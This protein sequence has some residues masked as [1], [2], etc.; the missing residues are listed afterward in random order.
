MGAH[1]RAMGRGICGNF[2]GVLL[3]LAYGW[4]SDTI[5]ILPLVQN[6]LRTLKVTHTNKNSVGIE[7]TSMWG[8][9]IWIEREGQ[10]IVLFSIC[11][12]L[13]YS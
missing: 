9:I 13:V 1:P 6:A 5:A 10:K 7:N 3:V 11:F 2:L 4:L 8:L 12:S